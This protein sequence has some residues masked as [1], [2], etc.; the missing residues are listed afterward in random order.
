M[1]Y[2]FRL[3]DAFM[4]LAKILVMK[5]ILFIKI[6]LH[7]IEKGFLS[8]IFRQKVLETPIK[9]NGQTSNKRFVIKRN[10]FMFETNGQM[11]T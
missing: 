3:K 11:Q 4:I 8:Q 7:N 10:F 1:F 2:S 6:S 5:V 9:W